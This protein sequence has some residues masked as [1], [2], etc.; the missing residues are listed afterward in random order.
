M[1]AVLF[2]AIKALGWLAAAYGGYEALVKIWRALSVRILSKSFVQIFPLSK[3]EEIIIV[4]PIQPGESEPATATTHHDLLAATAVALAMSQ[5]GVLCNLRLAQQLTDRDYEKN[6]F[7]ICGPKSN[8]TTAKFLARV[9]LPFRFEKLEHIGWRI[10]DQEGHEE[11]PQ[12]DGM[13]DYAIIAKT[14]NPWG[15][16]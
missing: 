11:H 16:E 3:G 14:H 13:R 2:F 7:L 8:A 4:C 6:L 5:R 10:T 9:S 15:V 12:P 1:S